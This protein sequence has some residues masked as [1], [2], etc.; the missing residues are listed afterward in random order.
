MAVHRT[1]SRHCGVG[2][3]SEKRA[4]RRPWSAASS[5]LHRLGH[6]SCL[7]DDGSGHHLQYAHRHRLPI[8]EKRHRATPPGTNVVCAESPGVGTLA[9][10]RGAPR[11]VCRCGAALGRTLRFNGATASRAIGSQAAVSCPRTDCDPRIAL[12]CGGRRRGRLHAWGARRVRQRG[13]RLR[14]RWTRGCPAWNGHAVVA[15]AALAGR[16]RGS[17]RSLPARRTTPVSPGASGVHIVAVSGE[18]LD[19]RSHAIVQG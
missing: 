19:C 6:T 13:P 12:G 14:G 1:G 11:R 7:R 15:H 4:R 17:A 5:S 18:D 3:L 2:C 16:S 9:Q 8:A 10:R